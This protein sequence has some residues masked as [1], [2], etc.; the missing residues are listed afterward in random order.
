MKPVQHISPGMKTA[1]QFASCFEP[2]WQPYFFV[3]WHK[4][5]EGHVCVPEDEVRSEVVHSLFP[6]FDA[7]KAPKQE[8][9]S[10]GSVA[11]PLVLYNGRLYLH[12]Y[13][14]Y[15]TMIVDKIKELAGRKTEARLQRSLPVQTGQEPDWQQVAA[16]ACLLSHFTIITGGP[17]TGKTT[18]VASILRLLLEENPSYRIALAAPTGKAAARMAESLKEKAQQFP[19]DLQK[20]FNALEPSTIHRLLGSKKHS[21]RFVHHAKNPLNYDVIV[22]DESSMIDVAMF[23]KLL[24]ATPSNARLIMLGDKHQLASVEAGSLFGDLCSVPGTLHSFSHAFANALKKLTGADVPLP[25]TSA[26]TLLN[27]HIVELRRSYRFS[28]EKG[29]GKFSR[30]LMHENPDALDEFLSSND[31]VVEIDFTYDEHLFAGF[32]GAFKEYIEEE[33][34]TLA[35]KKLNNARILCALR[36]G[37]FGQYEINRRVES[38]LEKEGLLRPGR[39]FYAHRPVMITRNNYSLGLFNGDIGI[40]RADKD[41][42]LKVWFEINGSLMGF[43]PALISSAETAFAL[44][45]HKSQGSEFDRVLILLP[46]YDVPVLTRELVYTAITRA[47]SYVLLQSSEAVLKSSTRRSVQRG[48]GIKDRF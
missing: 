32:A 19:A 43:A 27:D 15:E 41:G 24:E 1:F 38:I 29:I 35:L 18:T 34:I 13:F 44:T 25:H 2:S 6:D 11:Q 39:E 16:A 7:D 47:K 31:D 4:L 28:P 17:G 20:Q 37:A 26:P 36:E 30:L 12:K 33:D 21:T 3:L 45:I 23:A 22:I 48:S 8:F 14:V 5:Q 10:D 9:M 46:D 40:V 42:R